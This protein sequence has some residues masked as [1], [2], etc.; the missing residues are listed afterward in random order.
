MKSLIFLASDTNSLIFD[1]EDLQ[2]I[3]K[4]DTFINVTFKR[5]DGQ[6]Y[7]NVQCVS[8]NT[9][10]QTVKAWQEMSMQIKEQLKRMK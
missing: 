5:L 9:K 10:E 7:N 4:G 1:L 6:T 8:F 3:N 2:C